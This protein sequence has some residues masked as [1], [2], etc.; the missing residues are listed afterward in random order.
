[1]PP[2]KKRFVAVTYGEMARKPPHEP[3]PSSTAWLDGGESPV[4]QMRNGERV[5]PAPGC[6]VRRAATSQ[7]SVGTVTGTAVPPAA[8][9]MPVA[10]TVVTEPKEAPA[11][12]RISPHSAISRRPDAPA[13]PRL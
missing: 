4:I 11:V 6:A 12:K 5:K 3:V 13:Q 1:M 9:I 8:P 2:W 10:A 7:P